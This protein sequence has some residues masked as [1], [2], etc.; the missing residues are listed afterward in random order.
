MKNFIGTIKALYNI[1]ILP[2]DI[3]D[4]IITLSHH[5]HIECVKYFKNSIIHIE[6]DEYEIGKNIF[7]M[8]L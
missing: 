5:D 7:P 3:T 2:E 6:K 4:V 1:N 8:I